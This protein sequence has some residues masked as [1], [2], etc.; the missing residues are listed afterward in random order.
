MPRVKQFDEKEVLINAMNLFWK[1]GYAATS[2]QDLVDHVGINRASLYGTFGDKEE[3]FKKTFDHYRKIN[4]EQ[5]NQL[6]Q[7]QPDVKAG[8]TKLFEMAIDETINDQDR[9]G[10]FVVNTTTELV[11]GNEEILNI[12]K[13]NK[14]QV[15]H[16]FSTYLRKGKDTG[17]ISSDKDLKAIASLLYTLYN[18]LRV[19]AKTQPDRNELMSSVRVALSLLD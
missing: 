1:Q 6:F 11:P 19:V 15:E 5:I 7:N 9:K 4:L 8:F 18:G 17:Q 16:L 10:C 3:L 12:L 2:V 13:E 14:E